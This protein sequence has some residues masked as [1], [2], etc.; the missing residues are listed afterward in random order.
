MQNVKMIVAIGIC[1]MM[2][3]GC[4]SLPS[5]GGG[6][7]RGDFA[8]GSALEYRLPGDA[9]SAL[10]QAA[11]DALET[12]EARSWRTRRASGVVE[13][14]SYALANLQS[15]PNARIKA[16]RGDFD[17]G[18]QMETE[19]GLYVAIRKANVRLGPGTEHK[20]AEMI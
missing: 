15:N 9:R 17:L 6:A 13:P 7:P 1:T 10:A 4:S 18:H 14:A 3:A 5:M 11:T 19:M 2:M 20:V 16:G 12:G 8:A